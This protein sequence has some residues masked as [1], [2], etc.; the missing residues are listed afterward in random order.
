M[1]DAGIVQS[2]DGRNDLVLALLSAGLGAEGRRMR[3]YS[4]CL[5]TVYLELVALLKPIAAP[6]GTK[7]SSI[8][9]Y[10]CFVSTLLV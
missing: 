4:A 9:S 2:N 6:M 10:N 8:P 1:P 3:S 5:I 7:A